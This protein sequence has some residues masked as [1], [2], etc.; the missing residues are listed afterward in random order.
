VFKTYYS[1]TKPG[2][3]YGNALTAAAGFLLASKWHIDWLLFIAL[4]VGTSLGIGSA[5]VYNNYIDRDID[6]KMARTR[7]RALVSGAVT[8]RNALLFATVL[9][10]VG[11]VILIVF[12]NW[13]VVLA[14]A[15]GFVDYVFLYGISKRKSVYGTLVGSIS[16]AMPVVAG[17]VAVTDRFNLGALLL[18]LLLVLWQ[19]PHFYAIAMYRLKDYAAA[20]IPVLPRMSGMRRTKLQI[21]M[22]IMA[23][24]I[25]IG[26]LTIFGYTGIVFLVV[27]VGASL[28]WLWQGFQ[29][30]STGDDIV[31]ARKMFKYSLI[32]ILLLSVMLSVGSILA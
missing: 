13:L 29:G 19:M 23:F 28:V 9:G 12:T 24:I 11:F 5:C 21:I 30:I 27:M 25:A 14:G 22:Y 3:I 32:I 1:L 20:D 18:F 7:K 16:G 2:I 4:L 10:A 31:W 8:N 15:I 6:K 17:Y 26:L